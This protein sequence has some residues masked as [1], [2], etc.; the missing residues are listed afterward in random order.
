M[1]KKLTLIFALFFTGLF[2]HEFWLMPSKFRL[3]VNETIDLRLYV[4][5]DFTG[6]IWANRIKR[7]LNLKI[8]T[9]SGVRDLTNQ[10]IQSDSLPIPVKFT[11]EGT[12]LLSMASKNS[13]IALEADKFNDYLEEDGIENIYELRKKNGQLN[14]ASKEFYSRCAKSIV[15]VGN[16]T[17][18][19]Y[20]KN[21]GMPLEIIALK[22]PYLLKV[23]Q[24]MQVKV[25]YKNQP[26]ANKMILAW[27]KT[28]TQKTTH[29]KLRTDKN[30]VLSLILDKNGYWMISTVHMISLKNNPEADYQSYWGNLTFEL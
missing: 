16:K 4:G 14:K 1:R 11:T 6:E 12:H 8:H 15:Q 22:N 27:H 10:A 30:G 17:D 24:E 28:D 5:E 18:D 25:L 19:S 20:K 26:L 21:T 29:Q 7:L 13:F 9:K 2:A 3:A 23:G